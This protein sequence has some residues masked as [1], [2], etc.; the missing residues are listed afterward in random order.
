MIGKLKVH[1]PGGVHDYLPDECY[2]KRKVEEKIRNFFLSGYDE[3]ET[4]YWNIL[5]CLRG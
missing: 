1:L 3:V 4:P 5:M 2:N